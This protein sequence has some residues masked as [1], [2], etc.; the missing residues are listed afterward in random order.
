[1]EIHP[2]RGV[3]KE[4]DNLPVVSAA[5]ASADASFSITP[6]LSFSCLSFFPGN[7]QPP[8]VVSPVRSAS[9]SGTCHYTL[10]RI[11]KD[12]NFSGGKGSKGG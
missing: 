7:F 12:S 3:W 9:F 6:S 1:M 2:E 4:T 5:H 10:K 8:D 11:E